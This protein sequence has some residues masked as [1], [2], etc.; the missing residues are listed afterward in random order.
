MV[1][2]PKFLDLYS[3]LGIPM[4]RIPFLDIPTL[5]SG[6]LTTLHPL[7][8]TQLALKAGV[9]YDQISNV[10]IWGNHSTTQV[11]RAGLHGSRVEG[12]K[13][14]VELLSRV[15]DR[16]SGFEIRN[17]KRDADKCVTAHHFENRLSRE[18]LAANESRGQETAAASPPCRLT[19]HP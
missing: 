17:A 15:C 19:E 9:F 18:S 3:C 6:E 5:H 7:S 14:G 4:A 16:P 10:T 13:A 12:L 8:G 11:S 1:D 2:S